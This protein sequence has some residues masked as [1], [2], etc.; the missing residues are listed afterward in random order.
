MKVTCH[1]E[2]IEIEVDA[3]TQLTTCN[4]SICRRYQALWGY[5]SPQD[6]SIKIGEGGSQAY[7]WGDRGIDFV[8]CVVCGCVTHYQSVEGQ[9]N[10]VVAVNFRMVR[11]QEFVD[12]PRRFF[13]GEAMS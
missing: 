1:C 11:E 4:C 3:P 5:Y 9:A 10:P 2:N 13:D 8:H 6:V 7:I 12:V